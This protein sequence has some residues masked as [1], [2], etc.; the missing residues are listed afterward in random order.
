M[1]AAG[2]GLADAGAVAYKLPKRPVRQP[3]VRTVVLSNERTLSRWA[4]PRRPGPIFAGPAPGARRI[5]SV[6]MRTEDG[7]PEVYLLLREQIDTHRRSWVELRIPGRPNGRT[8]W[9]RRDELRTLEITRWL[10]VVDRHTERITAYR[11]GRRVFRAPVGI[12]KPSTPTPPGHF[13]IRERFRVGDPSSAYWPYALGTSDYSTL[14]EWPGGGVVG[15]HGQWNAPQ[16]IP[17]DPSHGC[18]R[19]LNHDIAWLAPRVPVG[20]PLHVI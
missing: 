3:S 4:N 6:H 1:L 10:L 9:V 14:S 17:G 12:G 5:G 13:W 18:I 2:V 8:G 11:D 16:L 7:F 20:T 19:M 15:I